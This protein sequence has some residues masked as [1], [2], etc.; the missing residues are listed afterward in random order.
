MVEREVCSKERR[1]ATLNGVANRNSRGGALG[2]GASSEKRFFLFKWF[3][4]AGSTLE[5][6]KRRSFA[7]SIESVGTFYSTTTVRSFAFHTANSL[8]AR[9]DSSLHIL[10]QAAEVGPFAAGASK[11]PEQSRGRYSETLPRNASLQS[12]NITA[13]YS[14]QANSS[15]KS[16]V[17]LLPTSNDKNRASYAA[18]SR[19]KRAHVKGKRRAPDPPA[20][21]SRVSSSKQRLGSS[22]GRKRAAP[23]APEIA[24]VKG[25]PSP[26][27]SSGKDVDAMDLTK[28]A[29]KEAQTISNDTLLL[30]GGLL[31]S[32]KEISQNA[33][34]VENLAE[35][36]SRRNS[37]NEAIITGSLNT[38]MPRPWYKR[39]VFD[40][41]DTASNF[42]ADSSLSRL[43]F[44]QKN[45]RQIEERRREVKRK[46]GLSILANISELDKEAAAIV[47][48]EEAR[49][50]AANMLLDSSV[51]RDV[52]SSSSDTS[53]S[54]RRGT[55]ALISKFNAISNITKVTVNTNFFARNSK[56]HTKVDKQHNVR[57][58]KLEDN[59]NGR[60]QS[61]IS[62]S[63]D[64]SKYFSP[65]QSSFGTKAEDSRS[66]GREPENDSAI[67][68]TDRISYLQRQLIAN[69]MADAAR[70]TPS[71]ILKER[72]RRLVEENIVRNKDTSKRI[73]NELLERYLFPPSRIASDELANGRKATKNCAKNTVD[74]RQTEFSD[75]LEEIDQQ[76]RLREPKIDQRNYSNNN[77]A[78]SQL[79]HPQASETLLESEKDQHVNI[80]K[81]IPFKL[82]NL[83]YIDE[84]P[85]LDLE[86]KYQSEAPQETSAVRKEACPV[87]LKEMLKE[88]KHSLPKR[89]KTAKSLTENN[90]ERLVDRPKSSKFDSNK[91]V[92]IET[93]V[94]VL[95]NDYDL[96]K[97][98]VSSSAQTSGNIRKLISRPFE[99][100]STSGLNRDKVESEAKAAPVTVTPERNFGGSTGFAK[101][102]FQLIRPSDFAEIEATKT[103]LNESS[104]KE[105]TYAN[106]IGQ[107]LYANT[108]VVHPL[109][110][111]PPPESKPF[112]NKLREKTPVQAS[113]SSLKSIKDQRDDDVFLGDR[114]ADTEEDSREQKMST[115][116]VNRL[117]RKLEA[118]IASGHHQQAAG[119]AKELARLKI[120]CSVVRQRSSRLKHNLIKVNIYIEDKLAHEGPIP[121][122]VPRQMTVAELKAK[123]QLEFEIPSNVQRWIIGK[124]LADQDSSTLE[125]LQI[126][127]GSS[128]FLYL[129]APDAL[130]PQPEVILQKTKFVEEVSE[131][132]SNTE[133]QTELLGEPERVEIKPAA[134]SE[135]DKMAEYAELISL[136]NCDV[137]PNSEPVECPICF[138]TFGP[139]E[140]VILKD[141][142]HM[143]C[144]PCLADTILYCEEAVVKCPYRDTDYTCEST[145]QEREIKALVA[146]DIYN[147]HLAKSISQA[148]NSAGN[149]AFHCKTPDCPG[150]CYYDDNVNNFLCPVCNVNN[151]LTCQAIHTG[152]NCKQY[153]E[154]LRFP[155]ETDYESRRTAEMLEEMVDRGEALSCPTCAVVLMKKWGCDWLRCSMCKT[156]I[157]WVTKGPRWGPKGNGDTSGGCRCGEN[158]IKCHPRCNYCH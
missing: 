78:R 55:R 93:T 141:C 118:A 14:L 41:K 138:L 113:T 19:K 137:I 11:L 89:S 5:R 33:K 110:L 8:P 10:K 147:H 144:R 126:V 52:A 155:K 37:S 157:C 98:K 81:N 63:R 148:E 28:R 107:S 12:K 111:K 40:H 79:E 131:E 22:T 39:A 21:S 146:P 64:I 140:G 139:R 127:E 54:P 44:L 13:R 143:F 30:R 135:A 77:N 95:Q 1:S 73:E 34:A 65:Q 129:V 16:C 150:W 36:Q 62:Q 104:R 112:I 90:L 3:K 50:R 75:F 103:R 76:L 4:R 35:L 86:R 96:E 128:L 53:S 152:K 132:A 133:I 58:S 130:N 109:T 68:T 101:S 82:D 24:I 153:Q 46:S 51:T 29:V 66:T 87:D 27:I 120:Q 121:L 124:S 83:I 88:M 15:Y 100:A 142:L 69:R 125:D 57:N 94:V 84:T 72:P 25:E 119:L 70:S 71:P 156:E 31:F 47:Q 106:V 134:T 123:V 116:A 32:N 2:A 59:A 149:N 48:E 122:Q 6:K 7:S 92:A 43:K 67:G 151:C 23:K 99:K 102:T 60:L 20:V 49:A 61:N 145:L 38:A 97:Q 117:L 108:A 154:R 56:D 9:T 17:S 105:S 18:E 45:E 91:P 115:L 114:D 74:H 42:P 158:G 85:D 26:T 136:E 80:K